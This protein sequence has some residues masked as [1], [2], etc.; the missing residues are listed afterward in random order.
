MPNK[1]EKKSPQKVKLHDL[2]ESS[3]DF[4]IILYDGICHL[5]HRSL[6]WIIHRDKIETFK[7]I[8]LQYVSDIPKMDSVLLVWKG[9]IFTKSSA[10]IQILKILKGPSKYLALILNILPITALNL[11]YDTVARFRYKWF[12]QYETCQWVDKS[13]FE[14]LK[15]NLNL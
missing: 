5:C 7:Y 13:Y 9:Q 2:K 4:P 15:K 1:S 11:L 8:P 10:T 14:E 3:H 12:G 6:S